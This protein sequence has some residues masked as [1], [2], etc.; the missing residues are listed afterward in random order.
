MVCCIPASFATV[1]DT[2]TAPSAGLTVMFILANG[3]MTKGKGAVCIASVTL[4]A[5]TKSVIGMKDS[6]SR[7]ACMGV[8]CTLTKQETFTMANLQ[9]TK[10]PAKELTA[11]QTGKRSKARV[12]RA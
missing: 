1:L 3:V 12:A 10:C 8:V 4:Q 9:T 7:G 6:G 5:R 2:A 11:P